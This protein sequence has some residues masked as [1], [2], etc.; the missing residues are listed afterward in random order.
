LP[1]GHAVK[2]LGS[3]HADDIGALKARQGREPLR[4][5]DERDAA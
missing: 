1:I 2:R 5:R 4:L 3:D